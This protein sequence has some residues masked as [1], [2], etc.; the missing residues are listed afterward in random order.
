[1]AIFP[2]LALIV[3]IPGIVC[4]FRACQSWDESS[5]VTKAHAVRVPVLSACIIML[6]SIPGDH[7]AVALLEPYRPG[8]VS[9]D[10]ARKK[11]V[12]DPE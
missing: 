3:S 11:R 5:G 12:L 2:I 7:G 6:F 9:V 8:D 4:G 10:C 1:M